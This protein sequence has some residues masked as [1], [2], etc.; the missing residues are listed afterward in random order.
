M[1]PKEKVLLVFLS[2]ALIF[3][4]IINYYKTRQLK[5]DPL[6]FNDLIPESIS[7]IPPKSFVNINTATR[8]ELEAL[9]GIG[10]AIAQRIIEYRERCRGFKRKE[11]ILKIKGIGPKKFSLLKDKITVN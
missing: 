7:E 6:V 3:G 9:P 5:K 11:E 4:I 10:P 2:T 8:A 1:N